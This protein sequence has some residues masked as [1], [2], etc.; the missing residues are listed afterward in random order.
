MRTPGNDFELATGFLATE[1]VVSK[2]EAIVRIEHCRE[3]QKALAAGIPIDAAV[4][5]PSSLAIDL[6]RESGIT[7]VGFLRDSTFNVYSG[8]ERLAPP[9]PSR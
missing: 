1:G 2:R 8:A 6:A 4:S 5:A 3:V 7:L 9:A